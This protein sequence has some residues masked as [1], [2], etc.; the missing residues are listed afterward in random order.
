MVTDNTKNVIEVNGISKEFNGVWVLKDINFDLKPGE[1][2]SL[3]G[4]NGAG[5]STFIKILSGVHQPSEGEM[6]MEGKPVSFSNVRQSESVGIRTVHQEVNLIPFFPI[7]KNIFVGS[8]EK[9][10]LAGIT[11]LDDKK[12]K[13]KAKDVIKSLGIDFDINKP[14]MLLNASMKRIVEISKVLI[15]EPKVI[16]FDEPTTSLGLDERK[17]LLKIIIGLKEKG[18]SI[19]YISHNLEEITSISDRITVFRD[20]MKIDTMS[21]KEASI[22]KIIAMMLGDKTYSCYIKKDSY[23]TDEVYFEAANIY[24]N[25]LKDVSFKLRKG[26]V[27]GVAGVVGAGKTE[28]ARV[29]FGIDKLEKGTMKVKGKDYSPTP[30]NAIHS[31]MALVPEERQAEG[32]IPN[33]SVLQ[34]TTLTYLDNWS[35]GGVIDNKKEIKVANEYINKLSIKTTGHSQLMKFLSGGNQQKVILSRWLNGGFSIGIFDEPT[36]GIDIKAKEDIYHMIEKLA[37]EGKTVLMLSSYLPELL[38]LSDRIIVVHE[39]ELVGEFNPKESNAE[40]KIM[41]AMLGGVK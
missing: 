18:H 38:C 10:K 17:R 33:F 29:M 15:H 6:W 31:G 23:Y 27:L 22:D 11:Y 8:E 2:H 20:G 9:I 3:V 5:K 34:N 21:G 37:K 12:M 39:G 35:R 14:T 25:R 7:Y 16:I 40:E 36:K 19:I 41:N 32:L 26:E 28:I 1:I 4:E 24:T 30:Q 13:K